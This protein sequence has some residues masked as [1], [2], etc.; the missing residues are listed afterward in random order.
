M[1]AVKT[2]LLLGATLLFGGILLR[3]WLPAGR[4]A[5]VI[6]TVAAAL[7]VVAGST[8]DIQLILSRLP[9]DLDIFSYL[10]NTRH[11]LAVRWR[12]TLVLAMS[13]LSFLRPA[14]WQLI[15]LLP[16]W[17]ALLATFSYTSHAAAMAGT[18]AL[19]I[20]LVHFT[21]GGVWA[22]VILA[23][24]LAGQLWLP[25]NRERLLQAMQAVSTTGLL[26][27]LVVALSGTISSLFHLSEPERFFGSPYSWALGIKIL[28]VTLTVVTAAVNRFRFLPRLRAGSATG[29]RRNLMLES[30]LLVA[31]FVA[32]GLLTT[33]TLPH[34]QDFP[35]LSENLSRLL[36]FVWR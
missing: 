27:V 4:I 10:E 24:S 22:G 11:G 18:A 6:A 29:L 30:A 2:L 31:V 28:L 21:A 17:L 33:S 13:V 15:L 20:D 16:C 19:V 26:S 12:V 35:G 3:H 7:A 32:T 9:V 25:A 5:G 34:G 36:D 23:V 14:R 1:V 8:L